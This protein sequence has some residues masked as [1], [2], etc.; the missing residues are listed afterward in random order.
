MDAAGTRAGPYRKPRAPHRGAPGCSAALDN[1]SRITPF[2][3]ASGPMP[4][5]IVGCPQLVFNP[6][7][8]IFVAHSDERQTVLPLIL[9]EPNPYQEDAKQAAELY[10][11]RSV[12]HR[13]AASVRA[14]SISP[15]AR[16]RHR[17]D[18]PTPLR[19]KCSPI[20]RTDRARNHRAA[21][22][23]RPMV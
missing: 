19:P 3:M 7:H 15:P 6:V 9:S 18:R 12:R 5:H 14:D 20:P 8:R 22:K 4:G 16:S 2:Q 1:H 17:G 11:G 23:S 21:R 13:R 10:V